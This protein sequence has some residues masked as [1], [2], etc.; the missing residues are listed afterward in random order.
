MFDSI[1]QQ[2][3][4]KLLTDRRLPHIQMPS[5]HAM[6]SGI[7]TTMTTTVSGRDDRQIVGICLDKAMTVVHQISYE[8][9]ILRGRL[10]VK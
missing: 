9:M 7:S 2:A 3:I 4:R 6:K 1:G 8:T 5:V 10:F